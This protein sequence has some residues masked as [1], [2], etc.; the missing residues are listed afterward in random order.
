[1][2]AITDL[3]THASNGTR[4]SPTTLTSIKAIGAASISC[5][6]LTGWPTST[7][8]HFILYT[9][10]SMG[11]KVAGS[12]TD[13]KGV[14]SGTT[15][16]SLTLKAGIDNGYGIGAV[17]E[18]SPTAAWAD[19]TV[20]G[21][22]L[23]HNQDGSHNVVTA[24]SLSASTAITVPNGSLTTRALT[25]P[26]N[27]SVYRST[28]QTIVQTGTVLCDAKTYDTGNN[29]DIITNKGRFTAPVSGF[30]QFNG[31]VGI[32][33]NASSGIAFGVAI[34]KNSATT[35]YGAVDI[36]MYSGSYTLQKTVTKGLQLVANDYV[37]LFVPAAASGAGT[38]LATGAITTYF[39]GFL[40]STT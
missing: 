5:A 16:S 29:V 24:T 7:A 32:V 9:L 40:K 2:A 34:V 17:V 15:I 11:K 19:D 22:L 37:E 35:Y 38:S 28:P 12:Q 14:A 6:A 25:N 39:E 27:F 4:P 20:N 21:L 8:V 18:A 33:I 10:D 3:F 36:N 13:W 30:Y 31:C 26:S 23:Q 1:M